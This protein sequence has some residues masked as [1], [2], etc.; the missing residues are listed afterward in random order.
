MPDIIDKV[1][2]LLESG[3]YLDIIAAA[4]EVGFTAEYMRILA[5]AGEPGARQIAG[6]WFYSRAAIDRMKRERG[7]R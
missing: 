2:R 7:I 3:D 4:R 5:R 6:K 1:N